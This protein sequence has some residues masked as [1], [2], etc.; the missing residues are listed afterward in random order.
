MALLQIQRGAFPRRFGTKI[1]NYQYIERGQRQTKNYVYTETDAGI[2]PDSTYMPTTN[3]SQVCGIGDPT[4]FAVQ[5]SSTIGTPTWTENH[6]TR[7]WN[8]GTEYEFSLDVITGISAYVSGVSQA[9]ATFSFGSNSTIVQHYAEQDYHEY[10]G[11]GTAT[12]RLD[13][14]G[15]WTSDCLITGAR[16]KLHG[17][18]KRAVIVTIYDTPSTYHYEV[19]SYEDIEVANNS[20]MSGTPIVQCETQAHTAYNCDVS[21]SYTT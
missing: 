15:T 12:V 18:F 2:V 21:L 16:S 7:T 17:F 4:L 11:I 20:P 9:L 19:G 5:V 14:N 3:M 13:S 1:T 8:A 10:S 6:T